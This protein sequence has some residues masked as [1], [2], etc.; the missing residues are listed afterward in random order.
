MKQYDEEFKKK[1]VR[2]HIEEGRS[3]KSLADEYGASKAVISKWTQN[4]AK[5]AKKIL[6]TKQN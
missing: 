6:V 2:L 4:V 1:I 3:L 5:N